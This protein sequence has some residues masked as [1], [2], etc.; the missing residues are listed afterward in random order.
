MK[1]ELGTADIAALF[2]V[3]R[4]RIWQLRKR[5][6][7]PAPA[8][9]RNGRDYWYEAPI[10]RW[11]AQ[12]GRELAERAPIL[13]R[14]AN[15]PIEFLGGSILDKQLIQTWATGHG[16]ISLVHPLHGSWGWREGQQVINLAPDSAVVVMIRPDWDN[17]G[18]NIDAI[19]VGSGRFYHIK[20]SDLARNLSGPPPWWPPELRRP[21]EMTRWRPGAP[22]A[23]TPAIPDLPVESL[24]QV[25]DAEPDTSTIRT[26]L[27][28]LART[29]QRRAAE[30]ASTDIEML[31][32][33]DTEHFVT[34]AARPAPT[35]EPGEMPAEFVRR[36]AWA[37]I[38]ARAD[39]LAEQCV[40]VALQ[41]NGGADFPFA[42][43]ARIDP[44]EGSAAAEWAARLVAVDHTAAHT[45]LTRTVGQALR[46]PVTDLPAVED[47]GA[48]IW[49]AVPQRLPAAT[50]L[51]EVI[52]APGRKVWI[53]TKGGT[54]YLCPEHPVNG[55]TYGY[56]G[57]GPH[58][59]AVLLNRLLD[60]ITA[61]SPAP[62]DEDRQHPPAGLLAGAEGAWKEGEVITRDQLVHAR[63]PDRR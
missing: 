63:K 38:L 40:S 62:N 39:Y 5:K 33:R 36:D 60:D 24:L 46:D 6:D 13:Y 10:L 44:N 17:N 1:H 8:G 51:A 59:L 21:E 23:V 19:D 55:I 57:T 61:P 42:T 45:A 35:R 4:P 22:T 14:P 58:N 16:R 2:G 47:E 30:S 32:E 37:N 52:L 29:L 11:A 28:H 48:I 43:T 34:L 56:S 26:A 15:L 53:R 12:A 9:T 31:E 7:F 3:S 18:P 41:W 54:L 50:D 49:A 25:A 27:T 20:W